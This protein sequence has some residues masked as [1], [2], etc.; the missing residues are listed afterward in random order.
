MIFC[1]TLSVCLNDFSN[2]LSQ[3]CSISTSL[4]KRLGFVVFNPLI[5]GRMFRYT[6][7]KRFAKG[8]RIDIVQ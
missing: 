1:V 4:S 3:C 8:R 5:F 7:K 6:E 2:V